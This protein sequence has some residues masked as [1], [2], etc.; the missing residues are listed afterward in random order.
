M[1]SDCPFCPIPDVPLV[2]EWPAPNIALGV[3]AFAPLNPVTPG[4]VLVVPRQH[5]PDAG[6][7]DLTAFVMACAA[8]IARDLTACNI[9]TSKGEA[10]SQTVYHLHVHVVPRYGGDGLLLPWSI[11][12]VTTSEEGFNKRHPSRPVFRQP[13]QDNERVYGG[14]PY[15]TPWG[16]WHWRS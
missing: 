5:Y 7:P 6:C 15:R 12:K 13:I 10:A 8:E 14:T 3:V 16:H 2:R 1:S 9:I 11:Q 4:H